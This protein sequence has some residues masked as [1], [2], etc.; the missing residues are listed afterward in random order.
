ML[1][2]SFPC[3]K[4]QRCEL[5]EF[6]DLDCADLY[7]LLQDKQIQSYLPGLLPFCKSIDT[8]LQMIKIFGKN[9]HEGN[10]I[11]WKINHD[12]HLIGFIGIADI[13]DMPY[14]FYALSPTH[15]GRGYMMECVKGVKA[16]LTVQGHNLPS[17]D[18]DLKN[19]ASL[20]IKA[21]WNDYVEDMLTK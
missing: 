17:I 1:T 13:S 12:D 8:A 4:T 21:F 20:K 6:S 14:L 18:T 5:L 3:M 19:I 7:L 16:Y 15:R 10:A 2:D 11:L 9:F